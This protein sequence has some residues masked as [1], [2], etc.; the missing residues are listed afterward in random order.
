V[1]KL[2]EQSRHTDF[3]PVVGTLEYRSPEQAGLNELDVD[4]RS[5]IYPL[6]VMMYELLT[7]STPID[8]STM[9]YAMLLEMLRMIRETDPSA[10]SAR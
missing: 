2:T 7:G 5:D 10:T 9:S 6:G 4:I 1:Q 8:R 3:G